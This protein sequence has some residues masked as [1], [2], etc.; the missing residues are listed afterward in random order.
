MEKPCRRRRR[1][2]PFSSSSSSLGGSARWKCHGGD[3]NQDRGNHGNVRE[4]RVSRVSVPL[5]T[6]TLVIRED[7]PGGAEV[8]LPS[9][10][11]VC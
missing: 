1:R 3:P 2:F 9:C 8:R 6:E 4:A 11:P 5:A 7:R 10:P